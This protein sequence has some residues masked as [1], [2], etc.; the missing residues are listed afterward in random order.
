MN[1]LLKAAQCM[2][3]RVL[4]LTPV[5]PMVSQLGHGQ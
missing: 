2:V 3:S 4:Y 1:T 5:S